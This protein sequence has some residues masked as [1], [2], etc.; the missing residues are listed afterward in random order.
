MSYV[1][2]NGR[3]AVDTAFSLSLVGR[4]SRR[5]LGPAG[6]RLRLAGRELRA[7]YGVGEVRGRRLV[8]EPD[9][10]AVDVDADRAVRRRLP[11]CRVDPRQQVGAG[12]GEVEDLHL[13]GLPRVQALLGGI[14]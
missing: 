4:M 9:H 6:L 1:P 11:G 10:G 12:S 14:V 13:V 3:M 2:V 5:A 8:D 7:R